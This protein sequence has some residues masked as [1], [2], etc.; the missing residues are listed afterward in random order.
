MICTLNKVQ[1]EAT[2]KLLG[3]LVQVNKVDSPE[4]I[5][6]NIYNVVFESFTKKD[7]QKDA[8][9]Y[10]FAMTQY[11]ADNLYLLLK[12]ENDDIRELVAKVA[13]THN[14]FNEDTIGKFSNEEELRKLLGLKDIQVDNIPSTVSKDDVQKHLDKIASKF[15]AISEKVTYVR[16]DNPYVTWKF[17]I[18]KTSDGKDVKLASVTDFV[19]LNKVK[20]LL[21]NDNLKTRAGT[22]TDTVI[23]KFF[24][25]PTSYDSFKKKIILDKDFTEAFRRFSENTSFP[26]TEA[27][28]PTLNRYMEEYLN[29]MVYAINFIQTNYQDSYVTDLNNLVDTSKLTPDEKRKFYIYS[30]EIGLTGELDLI[31]IKPDGTFTIIDIKTTDGYH[32]LVQQRKHSKQAS[33]YDMIISKVT[34]LKSTGT[35]DIIYLTTFINNP[36]KVMGIKGEGGNYRMS[37]S[38]Y[39]RATSPNTDADTLMKEIGLYKSQVIDTYYQNVASNKD[40]N[41]E[42]KP[43]SPFST[44][45]TLKNIRRPNKGDSLKQIFNPNDELS[46]YENLMEG[47]RWLHSIFPEMGNGQVEIIRVANSPV[48]GEFFID[49]IKLYELSNKGVAYHEGWHRFT[50]LFMTKGEKKDLYK[51]LQDD[52]IKF[53]TRDG[54]Q[55]TTS[56]ASFLDIEEFMAEEF[57]KYALNRDNYS[58]PKGNEQAKNWFQKI[59]EFIKSLVDFFKSKGIFAYED[60]FNNLYTGSFNRSNYSVNNAIF[61]H[62]NAFFVD[63]VQ[64]KKE[65]LDNITF[66]KFRDFSD[67]TLGQYL[68]LQ[69]ISITDLLTT[70]GVKE[71]SDVIRATLIARKEEITYIRSQIASE[72]QETQDEAVQERLRANDENLQ[73]FESA[74]NTILEQNSK[75][76]YIR[77]P[78]Y[79]RA[80]FKTS[81]FESLRKFVGDNQKRINQI[82]NEESL[83][84]EFEKEESEGEDMSDFD[85]EEESSDKTQDQEFNRS[86]NEK[87]AIANAKTELKDF[88]GAIPRH[89]TADLQVET[90]PELYEYDKGGLPVTLSKQE[91]FYKTLRVLQGSLTWDNIIQR[92]NT[93]DNYLIFPELLSVKEKLLG[94]STNEGLVPKLQRLS[95]VMLAGTA[96]N[97]EV[98]EHTKL[99][100]F[101]M[102]FAHVMSLRQV[103]FDTFIIKRNY[104]S[105]DEN[106]RTVRPLQTRNNLESIVWSIMNDFTKG[107][108]L[109]MER[110]FIN[111]NREY[112]NVFQSLYDIFGRG[113]QGLT[114]FMTTF[115]RQEFIYDPQYKKFYFNSM[116]VFK[117][118]DTNNP[119]DRQMKD[120]FSYLGINLNDKI[121]DNPNDRKELGNIYRKLKEIIFAFHRNTGDKIIQSYN[122]GHIIPK[123]LDWKS[124]KDA[125]ANPNLNETQKYLAETKLADIERSLAG[126]VNRIFT[127]NPVDQMLFDGRDEQLMRRDSKN[128]IFA[129]NLPT[130]QQLA[131][132]EK[133]YHKRFS[134]GSMLVVDKLQFSHFLPNNMLLTEM[135]INEHVRSTA[136]FAKYP[137]LA[138]LDPIQNPQI[139][140]SFIFNSIFAQDGSKRPNRKLGVSNISQISDISPQGVVE[141]KRMQD[142][143][144][145]EK[146]LVDLLMVI[147][148]GSAE[149]RRLET[150]NTAYRL[151]MQSVEGNDKY[152]IKPVRIQ[153]NDGFRNPSFLSIVRGYIQ[154]AA[155]KYQYNLDPK[156]REIDV[157]YPGIDKLGVFDEM[158]PLSS[159]KIKD[160]I[161][162]NGGDM[163]T[164]MARIEKGDKDLFSQIN[165]EIAQYFEDI[166][167]NNSDSYK[168]VF[169][170]KMSEKGR[171]VL[172]DLKS[173]I[174]TKT[175]ID[176][177]YLGN[178]EDYIYRDFIANDF[179]MTMEDSLLFFGDYTYYKDPIKRRKIIGNNG[180]INIV[181][182]IMTQAIAAQKTANSL[183]D[184]Y[185]KAK[186]VTSDKN[187]K[188]VKKTVVNDVKMNSKLLARN[189]KGEMDMLLKIQLLRKE[190]Y[191]VDVSL[192]QLEKEKEETIAAFTDIEVGDAAAWISLDM[193]RQMRLREMTWDMDKDE[194]EYK[195]QILMLK[196][197]LDIPLTDNER[198]HISKG[199]Y[200][201]FNVA[202]YA[203]TGPVYNPSHMPFKP[204]FDKM[205]LR[206]LLPEV[207]WNRK[208]RP[209]FEH[210]L[211][212]DTDYMVFDTGAK[213]YKP[214]ISEA[215]SKDGLKNTFDSKN[216][217]YTEHAGG[218]FKY[219]QNTT[220]LNDKSTFAVQLR[221][222]FYEIMLVQKRFGTVS[223]RL[224]NSYSKMIKSLSD[225]ITINSSR[226]LTEMGLHI[227]GTIRDRATF[228]NYL[229]NR[230]LEV[231]GVD[232][233]LISLLEMN[234]N[235]TLATY[236]EALPFQKNIVDLIAGVVDDN[237][238]K[239]KLNGTKFYQ[240][241]EIGTTI[242]LK[243]IEDIPQDMRG[244]IEL[245]WHDLEVV[246]GVPTSTTPVECKINFRSQ[247]R[248]LLNLKHPDG[249]KIA[250]YDIGED[251]RLY[252]NNEKSIRRLNEA[253]QNSEWVKTNKDSIVFVG[254]RIPL[255]DINFASHI[256]VKEF[257]PETVGDMII[258]PP[259]FYKQTG[260]DNDIDTVTAT[261]KYLDGSGKPIKRPIEDYNDII[262]RINDLSNISGNVTIVKDASTEERISTLKQKFIENNV[263]V[264][265][266]LGLDVM[267][268][269]FTLVEMEGYQTLSGMLDKKSLLFKLNKL[270]EQ[271]DLMSEIE[272]LIND[273]NNSR[274]IKSPDMVELHN[275][276]RKK[277]NYIK[278]ITNDLVHSIMDFMQAPENF[279]FLTET[280]SIARIKELAGENVSRKTGRPVD[281]IKLG[282]QQT[283]LQAMSYVMNIVN[284]KNNFE[285]RSILGAIIKARSTLSLLDMID[286]T[287]QK[288]YV[289]G[290]MINLLSRKETATELAKGF[291]RKRQKTY[292][293]TIYTPLLYKKDTSK[294][295]D[296][297][298]FD[299]DNQRITKNLSMIASSLLDL[300]KNMDVFPS[301][302]ISWLN[303][304]PLLFLMV[305]GVPMH[306]AIMF[307]NNPVVQEV[308]KELNNLG[309]DARDRHALV[310]VAQAFSGDDI[311]KKAEGEGYFPDTYNVKVEVEGRQVINKMLGRPAR[312]AENYLAARY[313]SFTEKD[314]TDFTKDYYSYISDPKRTKYTK[315]LAAFINA[316]PQYMLLAKEIT[317]YYATLLEDGDTFYA[318]FV[319]GLN[320]N[321]SKMNSNSAIASAKAV[322]KARMTTGIANPEFEDRL[323]TASTHAPFFNDSTIQ[324]V[325][326]NAMPN[327]LDNPDTYFRT[328]FTETLEGI[329][330][331]TFGTV[332]DKR[333]VEMRVLSDFIEFVYKNFFI[334]KDAFDGNTI[335]EYFQ[336]DITPLLG[337]LTQGIENYKKFVDEFTRQKEAILSD[338]VKIETL[339]SDSLFANQIDMFR[340]KYPE[341]R[342][343]KLVDELLN[344]K[345]HGRDA[346][347]DDNLEPKD[348]LNML[349]QSYITLNLSTNPKDKEA[350]ETIIRDE[351]KKMIEFSL[352]QFPS[353]EAEVGQKPDRID[354]YRN[355]D[356]IIEIRQFFKLLAYYSLA[357]SSHIDK[358]RASFSY[359]AP[360]S[361]IKEV[362][363]KAIDNFNKYIQSAG[364]MFDNMAT[365]NDEG[366]KKAI[367]NMLAK[368]EKT[369][370]DMNGDIK[371]QNLE[372]AKP[373]PSIAP[374]EEGD[375]LWGTEE[376]ILGARRPK[377]EGPGLPYL[378]AHTGKLYSKIEDNAI[379]FFKRRLAKEENVN[380]RGRNTFKIQMF[381]N[382]GDPLNCSI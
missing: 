180:S 82:V 300:F 350:E 183:T 114:E 74:L 270:G 325:L 197:K 126:Y 371:W 42:V 374:I 315:T 355:K 273:I 335:Y 24:S 206:V 247:F 365:G 200:S 6:K 164:L 203:L 259:E 96:T 72:L 285:V 63:S 208:T 357:Q 134:S 228:I 40:S 77:F 36:T 341:L 160:Y 343:I 20:N 30:A 329:T 239:I 155:W 167:I 199:P 248:P 378:K 7:M 274:K 168:N 149:I 125:V 115:G 299:E 17:P 48:G 215:F 129:A 301:L 244:T 243:K 169:N 304:K 51:Q 249:K 382:E 296:I 182:G 186:N 18:A 151:S 224:R 297:S 367:D 235:G 220:Q 189:E 108:Q 290:S 175:L 278:G 95:E 312:A 38:A 107:F 342:A 93:P 26:S 138:H 333:S 262:N 229:K 27:P 53:T 318:Y 260:S 190:L 34:G 201:A 157:N 10:A 99:M 102:H 57:R 294:G 147:S 353:I 282:Q 132:I 117:K 156:N 271:S 9:P 50:Q 213:V 84:N 166:T 242:E 230:L 11:A 226:S 187:N 12:T 142:L 60:M 21:P 154:H 158:L 223:S 61:N 120:F 344:K 16:S 359:L 363:E 69:D 153:R 317:A 276:N 13:G 23:R 240:S 173:I 308:Q 181:D 163:N 122:A 283:S 35:N 73:F 137:E 351:W 284:H 106:I 381:T 198:D 372:G 29:D 2:L 373:K 328:R 246:N 170:E 234:Q 193:T 321:S 292:Q 97:D 264:D 44:L 375:D 236:L 338:D 345:E 179:V 212:T 238:R 56:Q 324:N 32:T 376:A 354:F 39:N 331:Q 171:N 302:G 47:K 366:K 277:R 233:S 70:E 46:S 319:K 86:G 92:L 322:K 88:F 5:L 358:T 15:P 377:K 113:E 330:S 364:S 251:N 165:R 369:F 225:Y 306:R 360:P 22:L 210:M 194:K 261:F 1:K 133:N 286:T 314:I 205:G 191:G 287:L 55:L 280:D 339:Y 185:Q 177:D 43:F 209:L 279:D 14:Q 105:E 145:D 320:R 121:Y 310:S 54:R 141:S 87:E 103:D 348:I 327:I 41:Q 188:L 368:F 130:F 148:E 100:S 28:T 184:T 152:Y 83:V 110:K 311:F 309:S 288:Q 90:N 150:S 241:P 337:P 94:S 139:L 334:L 49:A 361:I 217:A 118:F 289:A 232:E 272:E 58:F 45:N 252:L 66:L 78:D 76:D 8:Q 267:D 216:A 352:T 250:F 104:S 91:A 172:A 263:Y 257:L 316:N 143:K 293:R 258:L 204:T 379:E 195:R 161:K 211:R 176:T 370:K 340:A 256:I 281:E 146:I 207:D 174:S 221:S 349:S 112:T 64:G 295:I 231:G 37:I 178:L 123:V 196:D 136:D 336:Y 275:L 298:I 116:Y 346:Q 67:F 85:T 303:V 347:K 214:A 131:R 245:K 162:D 79:M 119:T 144:E 255:Q 31:A 101:L 109:N 323:Q 62:L 266:G 305:Q 332:E 68:K 380:M 254:V 268:R 33:V 326:A 227:D 269:E 25:S 135:L 356:N 307:L 265:K 192:E 291:Q 80:Y 71:L 127:S 140:N 19:N 81:V 3:K 362:V 52:N 75:G 219:Q 313:L 237:F 98:Q 159:P 59:W 89:K 253:I 124:A 65:V 111:S 222:I 218:Y 128:K 4:A 202:K